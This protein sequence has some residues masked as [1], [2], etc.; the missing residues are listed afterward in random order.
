[1]HPSN[2]ITIENMKDLIYWHRPSPEQVTLMEE[3]AKASEA[4]MERILMACPDS[5]D[6]STAL[7]KVRE[8]RMWANSSIVLDPKSNVHIDHTRGA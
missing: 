3:I 2:K 5:A 4:L 8:A 6:R 7:R 1:M